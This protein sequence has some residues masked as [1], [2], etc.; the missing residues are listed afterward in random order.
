MRGEEAV[1]APRSGHEDSAEAWREGSG[2]A[3]ESPGPSACPCELLEEIYATALDGGGWGLVLERVARAFGARSARIVACDGERRLELATSLCPPARG[4]TGRRPSG[5][6]APD[7]PRDPVEIALGT[8][9]PGLRLLLE[10]G[11]LEA[12][13]KALLAR[14]IPHLARAWRVTGRLAEAER[15]LRLTGQTLDRLATGV[16]LVDA[17]GLVLVANAVA[18]RL[19]AGESELRIEA[20]H[21]VAGDPALARR[22]AA[23]LAR[24]AGSHS[25]RSSAAERLCLRVGVEEARLELLLLP[26]SDG[27]DVA[28][29]PVVLFVYDRSGAGLAPAD[30]LEKIYG[31]TAA[32]ARVV[33]RI[34]VGRTLEEIAGDLGIGRE[35]VRTHL[36]HVFRKVGTTRQADL[37]RLL[38][39]GP[40]RLR[41]S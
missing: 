37:V 20:G 17:A 23:A 34:L 19:L 16:A 11:P 12:H 38:L 7:G 29:A 14:L 15:R 18:E 25:E 8:E 10:R 21:L 9:T 5:A 2:P 36:Q 13:E 30:L 27:G 28:A 39:T 33:D 31:L 24:L 32:E 6:Q 41:W 4:Q 26:H 35:T 22:L 1:G 40:A 3:A